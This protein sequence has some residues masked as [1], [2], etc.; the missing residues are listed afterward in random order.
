MITDINRRRLKQTSRGLL[1]SLQE[2]TAA[3][4]QWGRNTATQAEIKVLILDTLLE[5]L[6]RPRY[7]DED[8]E[9]LADRVYEFAWQRSASG[10]FGG[11]NAVH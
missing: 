3:M 7:S 6:P 2:K 5:N 9:A 8:A 1:K 4:P 10:G 11:A